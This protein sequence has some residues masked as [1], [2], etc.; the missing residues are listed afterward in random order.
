MTIGLHRF[1]F[2]VQKVIF[3]EIDLLAVLYITTLSKKSKA[4]AIACLRHHKYHLRYVEDH[5]FQLERKFLHEDGHVLVLVLIDQTPPPFPCQIWRIGNQE[6]PVES[7]SNESSGT[8]S[9]ITHVY[10]DNLF[11]FATETLQYLSRLLSK[12]SVTIKLKARSV[13]IFRRTMKSVESAGE[14][15]EINVEENVWDRDPVSQNEL[16]KSVLDESQKAKKL[17]VTIP[18]PDNFEYPTSVPFKFD[19]ISMASTGWISRN[20]FI[21]LFLSCKK[22]QL[23]WKNFNDEDLAAI[24]KAW[25]E[26][27][28]LE[29]LQFLGTQHFYIGKTL[30]RILEG[31]PGATPVKNAIVSPGMFTGPR[32][33]TFGEGKCYRIQQ[34]DGQTTALVFI[35]IYSVVL[36]TKFQIGKEVDEMVARIEE[37]ER[38]RRNPIDENL[39]VEDEEED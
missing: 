5:S 25:T 32:I 30:D 29:V 8:I 21:K 4:T 7:T 39:E 15:E 16:V 18:T 11:D 24:F 6:V 33:I 17:C 26:G 27:S 36:S 37:E 28:P 9:T 14:I 12:L 2:L 38:L 3:E 23:K 10:S 31:I 1:P 19:S 13:D 34:R 22:V 35:Y 20:H